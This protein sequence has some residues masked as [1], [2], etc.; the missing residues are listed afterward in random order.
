VF[1][2]CHS[3]TQSKTPNQPLQW[4]PSMQTDRQANPSVPICIAIIH[5]RGPSESPPGS[6]TAGRRDSLTH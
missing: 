5:T 6:Y 4:Q 1:T 3:H 2:E